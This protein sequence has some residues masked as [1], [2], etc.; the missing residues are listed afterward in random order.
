MTEITVASKYEGWNGEVKTIVLVAGTTTPLTGY[1]YDTDMDATNGRAAQFREIF[2]AEYVLNSGSEH[3]DCT[4]SN[5]TGIVTIG[6][7]TTPTSL[8][9]SLTITGR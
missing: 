6:A 1:T 9:G 3:V 4:F 8:M 5:S 7:I 2:D